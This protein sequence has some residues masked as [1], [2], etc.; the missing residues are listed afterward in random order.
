LWE[1]AAKSLNIRLE[2][3]V[4]EVKRGEVH[5]VT[6]A[7]GT[8]EFDELILACPPNRALEFMDF[9][10]FERELLSEVLYLDYHVIIANVTG[11]EDNDLVF[12]A[13]NLKKDNIGRVVGAYRRWEE[14]DTWTFYVLS[15]W[16]KDDAT[17]EQ[18]LER[19]LMAC[20]CRLNKIHRHQKWD[21][22]PHVSPE[23]F[24]NG[25]Y[26]KIEK[27]NGANHTYFAGEMVSSASLGNVMDYSYFLVDRFFK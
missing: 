26:G 27:L 19:E 18:T 17:L 20:G 5:L 7:A 8:E 6:T 24:K 14:A 12:F 25:F 1:K 11:L 23:S 4:T 22:F 9:S 15:D 10:E 16:S 21:Y 3:P 2:T 13:N